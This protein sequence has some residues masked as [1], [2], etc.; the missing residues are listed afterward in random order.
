[1][2]ADNDGWLKENFVA[3]LFHFIFFKMNETFGNNCR[4]EHLIG[5]ALYIL[6]YIEDTEIEKDIIKSLLKYSDSKN[7]Q[8]NIYFNF[9][10]E[11]LY[12]FLIEVRKK[13]KDGLFKP[14][15]YYLTNEM[16]DFNG[17]YNIIYTSTTK[18]PFTYTYFPLEKKDT[19]PNQSSLKILRFI[20]KNNYYAFL[21]IQNILFII[22]SIDDNNN[23]VIKNTWEEDKCF[24][25][26]IILNTLLTDECKI[27][28]DKLIKSDFKYS[29]YFFY[30]NPNFNPEII[31][32]NEILINTS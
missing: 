15:I 22:T 20:L 13:F 31:L 26:D 19:F 2:S 16:E 28:F 27:I 25:Y 6:K 14:I 9:L 17:M 32:K 18:M 29:I 21:E 11:Q 4:Y 12:K 30:N 1:M 8:D 24:Y 7:N 23:L 10:I 3:L 5:S